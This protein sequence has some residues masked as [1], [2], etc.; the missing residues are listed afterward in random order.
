MYQKITTS[1]DRERVIGV[2][3]NVEKRQQTH[4]ES[5]FY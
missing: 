4:I 3:L 1:V 5:R 2:S